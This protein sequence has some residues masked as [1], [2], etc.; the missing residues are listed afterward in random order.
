MIYILGSRYLSEMSELEDVIDI[1]STNIVDILEYLYKNVKTDYLAH[2]TIIIKPENSTSF[3]IITPYINAYDGF[4]KYTPLLFTTEENKTEFEYLK[5]QLFHWCNAIKK[6]KEKEQE[7]FQ[8]L[9]KARIEKEERELYERLKAK[10]G[11]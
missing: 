4:K 7:E 10:Y 6:K 2:Y 1:V 8:K 11:D 9:S 5:N 3:E